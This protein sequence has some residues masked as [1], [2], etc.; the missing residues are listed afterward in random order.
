V[1]GAAAAVL[2]PSARRAVIDNLHRIRGRASRTRDVRDV[3]AT[4]A[5]YASCLAEVLSNEA[6][7]GPKTA[8]ATILGER[9]IHG[10]LT[11]HQG[12]V[13]VTAHTAGWE[14][15]GPLLSKHYA[16]DIVLVMQP[17]PDEAARAISDHARKRA[18]VAIAHVGDPLASIP[19]LRHLEAKGI[20]ALQ[21]DRFAP[22]MRTRA[23]EIL[24]AP[25]AIPEGPLRLA[26]LS[27]APLLPVFC[28]RVGYRR[29]VIE[30]FAPRTIPRRAT[31]AELDEAAAHIG[32]SLTRFL[33]A[34]PTQWF[35]WG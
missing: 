9:H 23:A 8:E 27:G 11:H 13:L 29:Y 22:G 5:N 3:L 18:G 30:A 19:L 34:H 16:L 4:F 24:D 32:A 20:V 35:H 10:A 6:P 21:V 2:V 33:R 31:D 12:I 1:F 28:A 7:S 14:S 25:S 15:A 26:Q 17:E